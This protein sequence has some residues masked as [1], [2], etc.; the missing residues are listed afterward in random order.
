MVGEK[1]PALQAIKAENFHEN[2]LQMLCRFFHDCP[3]VSIVAR[4]RV[5]TEF[6]DGILPADRNAGAEVA[7]R[8][9]CRTV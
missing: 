3:V 9:N 1:P 2:C 6:Q 7:P 4:G 8:L 5:G